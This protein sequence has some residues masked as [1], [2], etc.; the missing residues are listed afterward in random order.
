MTG[1]WCDPWNPV[2]YQARPG[3]LDDPNAVPNQWNNMGCFDQ[4]AVPPAYS[5]DSPNS[6]TIL[7]RQLSGGGGRSG[8]VFNALLEYSKGLFGE[9]TGEALFR[10]FWAQEFYWNRSGVGGGG[11]VDRVYPL[12]IQYPNPVTFATPEELAD[13]RIDLEDSEAVQAYLYSRKRTCL[14]FAANMFHGWNAYTY[15]NGPP[16][17]PPVE[18]VSLWA[19]DR[20]PVDPQFEPFKFTRDAEPQPGYPVFAQDCLPMGPTRDGRWQAPDMCA[21][22][23]LVGRNKGNHRQVRWLFPFWF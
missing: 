13:A 18:S 21:P 11:G 22:I 15:E 19:H 6:G 8:V 9:R 16:Y 4:W 17:D 10:E 23:R 20:L 5:V 14:F 12:W 2:P 7:V 3:L 1:F